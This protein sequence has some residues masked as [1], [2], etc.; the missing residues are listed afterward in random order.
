MAKVR[1]N[2]STTNKDNG[3]YYTKKETRVVVKGTPETT[4]YTPERAFT[5][6]PR[7][8]SDSPKGPEEQKRNVDPSERRNPGFA[9]QLKEA[10][11]R[12]EDKFKYKATP[13]EKDYKPG[14]EYKAGTT[15]RT[16][17]TPD[18][19]EEVERVSVTHKGDIQ[20]SQGYKAKGDE[21][22]KKGYKNIPGTYNY[23]KP[24]RQEWVDR[25]KLEQYLKDNPDALT[26][27][28]IDQTVK[29]R[30]KKEAQEQKEVE[31]KKKPVMKYKRGR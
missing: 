3:D 28:G 24:K 31:K 1:T 4:E 5:R 27:G 30:E 19:T 12:K 13:G 10:Q 6:D 21:L 26:S 23:E 15:K 20:S 11:E 18:I 16:P 17:A 9:K 14:L 8:T 22:E 25:D 2:N 7:Y 29:G